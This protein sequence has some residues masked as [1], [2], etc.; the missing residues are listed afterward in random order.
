MKNL[1]S[2]L[3]QKEDQRKII[4]GSFADK[5]GE[6]VKTWQNRYFAFYDNGDLEYYQGVKPAINQNEIDLKKG[7]LKGKISL[8]DAKFSL[9]YKVIS[10]FLKFLDC[11]RFRLRYKHFYRR[12]TLYDFCTWDGLFN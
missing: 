6:K 1:F 9:E 11:E 12:K 3:T 8:N 7:S 5:Q 2:K 4:F 10:F